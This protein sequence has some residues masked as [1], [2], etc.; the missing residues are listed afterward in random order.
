MHRTIVAVL[1]TAA[2]AANAQPVPCDLT[3]SKPV[4]QSYPQPVAIPDHDPNGIV[5]GPIISDA[6]PLEV[7][8]GIILEVKLQHTWVGDLRVRLAYDVN[9]DATPEAA[10]MVLCRP[11]GTTALTPAPCG[12]GTGFGCSGDLTCANTYRFDD[13]S[14]TPLGVGACTP[15]IP[16][17]CYGTAVDGGT[18]LSVFSG[19]PKLGCWTLTVIDAGSGDVGALCE[20]TVWE[21]K[22]PPVGVE[23]APWG[24]IKALYR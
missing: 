6:H 15:T 12:T 5:F 7:M 10:A 1:L 9:C 16:S 4:G 2:A 17:G 20:W 14:T 3:L 13:A 24:R 8:S 23:V 11:R 19:L 21:N 22:Q 18:P